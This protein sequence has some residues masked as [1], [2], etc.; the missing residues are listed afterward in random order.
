MDRNSE[1]YK[2]LVERERTKSNAAK[3]DIEIVREIRR[4]HEEEN[5][6]YTEISNIL[7]INRHTVYL[8]ATYRRWKYVS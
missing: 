1:Q 7:N 3:Y 5:K 8:I 6:G 4:L 2:K